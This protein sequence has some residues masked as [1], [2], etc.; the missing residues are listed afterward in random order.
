M[1]K[2]K[3]EHDVATVDIPGA[4]L[5]AFMDAIVHVVVREKLVDSLSLANRKKYIEYVR[6]EQGLKVL[7]LKIKGTI[8]YRPCIAIILKRPN[9]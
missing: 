2:A 7:Y 8:W 9:G 3:E 1:T 6:Y 4:F 5:Q